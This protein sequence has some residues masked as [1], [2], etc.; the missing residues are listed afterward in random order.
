MD[1]KLEKYLNQHIEQKAKELSKGESNDL[2]LR[3]ESIKKDIESAI[4][5]ARL[6]VY[7]YK[8]SGL[9]INAVEAEGGLRSL[10]TLA[11]TLN[12]YHFC[13]NN[14]SIDE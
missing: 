2:L 6:L 1:T 14:I 7:D 11:E 8:E 4:T 5:E 12:H 9:S 3:L 10:I 13:D